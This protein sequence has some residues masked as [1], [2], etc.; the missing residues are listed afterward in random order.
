MKL[1]FR[2][3]QEGLT[4]IMQRLFRVPKLVLVEF[5]QRLIGENRVV[6]PFQHGLQQF[7]CGPVLAFPLFMD[8]HSPGGLRPE[9]AAL[10]QPVALH[11]FFLLPLFF[12]CPG[13]RKQVLLL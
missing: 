10:A 5:R 11:G 9:G 6:A 7:G 3:Q 1:R 13:Q 2:Q 8:G 4:H 12:Q